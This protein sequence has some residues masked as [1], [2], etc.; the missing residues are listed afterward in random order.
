VSNDPA[1][2]T[3]T[4]KNV[5]DQQFLAFVCTYQTKDGAINKR[6]SD[7]LTGDVPGPRPSETFALTLTPEETRDVRVPELTAATVIMADGHSRGGLNYSNEIAFTWFGWQGEASRISRL[8]A[9]ERDH[10]AEPGRLA[11][12]R[13]RLG[14]VRTRTP[15]QVGDT[16][17]RARAYLQRERSATSGPVDFAIRASMIGQVIGR[18][19]QLAKA[20]GDIDALAKRPVDSEADRELLRRDFGELCDRYAQSASRLQKIVPTM[21]VRASLG[22][23]RAEVP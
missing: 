4:F 5:S 15:E 16:L 17:D 6:V 14:A 23:R 21:V 7:W 3:F 18:Q 1:G 11:D 20:V 12:V 10:I 9:D 13:M 2:T 19:E 8:F 22:R